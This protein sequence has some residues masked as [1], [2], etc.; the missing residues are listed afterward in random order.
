MRR[1]KVSVN[2]GLFVTKKLCLDM[3]DRARSEVTVTREEVQTWSRD[4]AQL[5][6]S[7]AELK[8]QLHALQEEHDVNTALMRN[9]M[10][11]ELIDREGNAARVAEKQ[12]G[13]L[14]SKFG[15]TRS[16]MLTY[17]RAMQSANAIEAALAGSATVVSTIGAG[18]A[19]VY[20]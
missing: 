16:E 3:K 15:A 20:Q 2:D 10:R 6:A 4:V 12:R 11:N 9:A 8:R 7:L 13:L 5:N 19:T 18:S 1:I 14:E 17:E